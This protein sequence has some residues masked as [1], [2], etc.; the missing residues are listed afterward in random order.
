M[1]ARKSSEGSLDNAASP[2]GTSDTIVPE[3]WAQMKAPKRR[4]E[5][6]ITNIQQSL[7]KASVAIL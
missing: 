6:Q 2:P 5:L 7:Q 3:I 1:S 4:T